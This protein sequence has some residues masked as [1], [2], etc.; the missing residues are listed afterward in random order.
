MF[1]YETCF[2]PS[3]YY[4]TV[5]TE[6]VFKTSKFVYFGY[7]LN[8]FFSHWQVVFSCFKI[9]TSSLKPIISLTFITFVI[10][11]TITTFIKSTLK[12]TAHLSFSVFSLSPFSL[13]KCHLYSLVFSF[14]YLS[15]LLFTAVAEASSVTRI[16]FSCVQTFLAINLIRILIRSNRIV[17]L[18]FISR[19]NTDVHQMT[20]K[21]NMN[22][23]YSEGGV[24]LPLVSVTDDTSLSTS[25]S[26]GSS[27]TFRTL[28]GRPTLRENIIRWLWH[29]Q[30]ATHRQTGYVT[31]AVFRI[32]YYPTILTTVCWTGHI[33]CTCIY[34]NT[35][36]L[37]VR[38][39]VFIS[40][41]KLY[42][43]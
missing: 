23:Q 22:I 11:I 14:Y 17:I 32:A 28:Q 31:V 8:S 6:N 10:R 25:S 38:T 43:T 29:H 4:Y 30:S 7:M 3:W 12:D 35:P 15:V 16:N 2:P 18:V 26:C 36:V 19:L 24:D 40:E 9:K 5:N 13:S 20:C 34:Y 21:C 42:T 39:A 41:M 27:S 33:V 37:H 1:V